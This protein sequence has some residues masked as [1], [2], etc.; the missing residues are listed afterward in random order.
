MLVS[1]NIR[2]LNENDSKR[3]TG[4]LLQLTQDIL[5]LEVGEF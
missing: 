1:R 2:R 5:I 3:K 4:S